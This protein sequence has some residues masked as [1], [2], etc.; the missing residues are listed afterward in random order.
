MI[1][2]VVKDISLITRVLY[3][4]VRTETRNGNGNGNQKLE[5]E[6]ETRNPEPETRNPEPETLLHSYKTIDNLRDHS[7]Y[8]YKDLVLISFN[9]LNSFKKIFLKIK[10]F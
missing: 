6:T 2:Q 3:R 9:D 8:D 10:Y 7:I 4:L 5:T 1:S